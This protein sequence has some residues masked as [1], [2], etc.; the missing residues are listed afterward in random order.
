MV[1]RMRQASLL[2]AWSSG[3]RQI[4][5]VQPE[6]ILEDQGQ[7]KIDPVTE[8]VNKGKGDIQPEISDPTFRIAEIPCSISNQAIGSS[9]NFNECQSICCTDKYQPFQPNNKE[10]LLNLSNNGLIL[11]LVGI[12]IYT[13]KQLTDNCD[14]IEF[15]RQFCAVSDESRKHFVALK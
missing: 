1:K 12:L 14:L 7:P 8:E 6:I 15:A 4:V 5:R 13:P 9:N 2:D 3:K 11:W 10:M